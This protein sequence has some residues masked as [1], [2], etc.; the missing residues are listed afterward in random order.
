M[1]FDEWQ[2]KHGPNGGAYDIEM[3]R[4][5]WDGR[6][7][8]IYHLQDEIATLAADLATMKIKADF[9]RESHDTAAEKA[10]K[11]MTEA[12]SRLSDNDLEQVK[13]LAFKMGADTFRRRIED[14][15]NTFEYENSLLNVHRVREALLATTAEVGRV[16]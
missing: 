16:A 1:T 7:I 9:W 5:G 13:L 14:W 15:L 10:E 12:H 8:E 3:Q 6:Q 2:Q 4:A 11:W